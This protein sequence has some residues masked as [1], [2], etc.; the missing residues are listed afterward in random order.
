L[1][2]EG[3]TT[4]EVKSGYGLDSANEAKMLRVAKRLAGV[5][6]KTTFLG[7]HA[8]PPEFENRSG[9]YIDLVV[10][11]MLPAVAGL[12]DAVDAF[13]EKIAFSPAETRRV[14]EGARKHRLPVK[15]HAD[16]LSDL[17]GAALA[18]EFGAL[19][20]DH[21]EFTSAAGVDALARSGTVAVLLPGAFY[22]LREKQL[23][24]IEA[25]RKAG[26]PMALATDNN[27]GSSPITSL[28]L[29]LNMAS[30]LFRLTPEEA[31]AGV[32]RHAATALGLGA[33]HGT[34]ETGK[35]ADFAIFRIQRP[36]ELAYRIGYNPCVGRV[37][38]GRIEP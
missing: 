7:A 4:L 32:T 21:L 29:V 17:G 27:P 31:L 22:F 6:V 23:P 12:A 20:A 14:F 11:E 1:R 8:L 38:S 19:S 33:T 2:A 35:A 34:L 37:R 5:S 16:Q 13:C 10:E 25:L 30:T 36:A 15:L 18:A 24:P 28:L 9:A 26:V 3:V